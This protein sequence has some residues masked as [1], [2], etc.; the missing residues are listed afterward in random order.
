[1]PK[2]CYIRRKCPENVPGHTIHKTKGSIGPDHLGNSGMSK[3]LAWFW[4]CDS[5]NES[6][7]LKLSADSHGMSHKEKIV[8]KFFEGKFV[9]KYIIQVF[10]KCRKVKTI[11]SMLKRVVHLDFS[12]FATN[13][14]SA[15]RF[16]WGHLNHSG[17]SQWWLQ[18]QLNFKGVK[19]QQI[20]VKSP[21]LT[22]CFPI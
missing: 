16:L 5:P 13:P 3:N 21:D 1:M 17:D 8:T 12:K 10:I 4:D 15:Y 19:S 9:I 6:L 18:I 11:S 7:N 14:S 22:R 2:S 20:M